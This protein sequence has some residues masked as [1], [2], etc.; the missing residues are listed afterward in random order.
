MEFIIISVGNELLRGDTQNTNATYMAKRLTQCGHRIRRI[1]VVP[2]DVDEI[3]TEVRRA[4]EMA[5]F[6]LLTGGLG[7]THD[8]VTAEGVALSLSRKLVL[9][10]KA[11]ETMRGR[12]SS[13][14]A[15]RKM[16]T[17]PEGSEVIRN[18][19][20]AAPGFIVENVAVMPG[21]P[22]EM[23]NIF[24]KLLHRFGVSD[25]FEETVRVEGFED[26]I[27]DK[28]EVVVSEFPDVE[29]GSYP[30]PGYIVIKF[31]G[32][33]KKKVISAKRRFIELAGLEP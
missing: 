6:T 12:V 22:K 23:E 18:D 4:N 15:I 30:K 2:D 17:L 26:R 9:S 1:T 20:G 29:I 10:A 33:D 25:Y 32:K 14:D 28:L 7:A 24:E 8:D 13:E 5:D 19:V 11:V 27:A 16:A 31:T 3:S 21:V